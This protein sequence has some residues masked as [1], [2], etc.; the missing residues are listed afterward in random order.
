MG[1]E[2]PNLIILNGVSSAG[3]SSIA[4]AL[5]K[6]LEDGFLH[7]QMDTFW[8]MLPAG[9]LAREFPNMKFAIMDSAAALLKH[10]HNVILDI[11]CPADKL[12]GLPRPLSE[13]QP[14]V[15]SVKAS[16]EVLRER[17][18]LRQDR[19]QG[20]AESQYTSI[21]KSGAAN[22]EID[23]SAM[24][25]EQSASKIIEAY[26]ARLQRGLE[27]VPLPERCPKPF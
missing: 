11:V 21:Y 22:L 25:A 24:T 27:P 3:K 20:L 26:E 15:V 7:F 19:N 18:K 12:E 1:S 2:K 10:G 8:N 6:R 5:Q 14:Y 16:L 4:T 13:Y 23:T 9:R 17:E